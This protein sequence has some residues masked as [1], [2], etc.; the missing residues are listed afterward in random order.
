MTE[1]HPATFDRRSSVTFEVSKESRT[2]KG[3]AVPFGVV[4]NNGFGRYR[5][6]KGSLDWAKVKYLDGHDWAKA[7]G[8]V[9][10]TETDEGLEM[11]A[12]IAPGARGDQLLALT[13]PDPDTG[14][15]VYDGLSIGLDNSSRFEEADDGVLDCISATVLEVSGTPIPAF[16][17]AQVRSVAASAT[18]KEHP[19]EHNNEAPEYFAA[20]QGMKL[21]DDV[22]SLTER[23][24]KLE[25]IKI[26]VG[27]GN[28]TA[29]FQVTEEPIYRFAG[30][31]GA[32]SGH[33][34]AT[35]L[36]A[37]GKDGDMAALD[38]LKK[39]T[40][41]HLAP[42][43]PA[44][45]DQPT[46]TGDVAQVNPAQYRPDM[47][48]GQAPTPQSP[49]YD[50][51]HKGGL[52]NVTPFFWSKL[53]RANTDVGVADHV[54]D[55]NPESRDLVTIAGA[56]VTPAP[57]SGRVHITR[58]V[59]DQGGNPQVSG[60]IWAEF[61]RSFKIALETKTAALL[62]AVAGTVT[63]LATIDAGSDG[64][65]A[66]A[67]IE[68]GLIDLQ[69]LADGARFT[70]AFGHVDLYKALAT[71][72]NTDGEKRYPIINPQ[73]RSGISGDKYSFI[74]VAGYRINPAA[75]LGATSGAASN[76]WLAD[77]NA[78]HVWNSGLQRL[79]K[80]TETVAGW[81][82]AVFAY[83]AGIVYDASG[84]RKVAYDP[85]V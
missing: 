70:K 1:R 6:S 27:P 46:T 38:R 67:A 79:D 77:P 33:D 74:D 57:V 71:Y 78:V 32:P 37:A 17:E 7:V 65:E 64:A 76:S 54:E 42:T 60:L 63:A 40:A 35:D 21:T 59:A 9:T 62:A 85:T 34:F 72:E 20:D 82:M 26:P 23:L 61:D 14:E 44:F 19:M 83:W 84:L 45:A 80:L 51:F 4:G 58:E 29:Q 12:K 49:L 50:T 68:A 55:V 66:G 28:G 10:F 11:T 25:D 41:E 3:L 31:V 73:N 5:F 8:T 52:S 30:N 39:F 13:T 36:L 48:L 69:F 56:T 2:I 53:D 16:T 15:A 43:G 47:F 75:S 22:Q 18:P 24:A 81:D